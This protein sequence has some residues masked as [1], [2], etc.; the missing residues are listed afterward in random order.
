MGGVEAL[1]AHSST[2][3]LVRSWEG[4]GRMAS[5]YPT[6]PPLWSLHGCV[7]I[8]RTGDTKSGDTFGVSIFFDS[9]H[10]LSP[11]TRAISPSQRPRPQKERQ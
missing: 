4:I 11:G 10:D 3:K 5:C 6:A 2:P 7:H 9:N 8:Q 1:A